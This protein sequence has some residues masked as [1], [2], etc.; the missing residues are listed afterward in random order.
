MHPANND[1]IAPAPDGIKPPLG[2]R[3][4]DGVKGSKSTKS[5]SALS[6]PAAGSI[7]NRT[8]PSAANEKPSLS[9]RLLAPF[10]G[11]K[12]IKSSSAPSTPTTQ[13]V[14]NSAAPGASA[15]PLVTDIGAATAAAVPETAST[16]QVVNTAGTMSP[17][18]VNQGSR[19]APAAVSTT[20]A[21]NVNQGSPVTP[22]AVSTTSVVSV[23][24]Q[25]FSM[26][27]G[28][29]AASNAS[30]FS[31]YGPSV[32]QSQ[33]KFKE[34]MN[35]ALDG[36]LTVLRVAKQASDWNPFLNA[37][38]GSIM[39][40]IDLAETVSSNSQDMKDTLVR[41]QGLLPVLNTSAKRLEGHK[42][43]FGKGNNLMTF[44]ITMQTELEKIQQMQLHGL[45]RRVLQGPKDVG[46]LLGIYKNINEALEQFKS[47]GEP[48]Y[49]LAGPAG[50]GKTTVAK[51][52]CELVDDSVLLLLSPA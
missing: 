11:S 26:T 21:M 30:P 4:L 46:T 35:V 1:P 23:D 5:S 45:F 36:C 7:E 24:E 52:I 29:A 51:T 3:F 20:S 37:A 38:L 39:A 12:F 34:G 6:T 40:V 49:W 2:K 42:D 44:A 16:A 43:D 17:I 15:A 8:A 31:L 9:K 33:S 28:S 18:N 13:S 25:G 48:V 47:D 22:T 32:S 10:K 41:I 50:I 27:A 19:A 14:D